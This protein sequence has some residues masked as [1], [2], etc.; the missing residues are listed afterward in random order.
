MMRDLR[1]ARAMAIEAQVPFW[2]WSA[3]GPLLREFRLMSVE[4]AT[5]R[6]KL[7]RHAARLLRGWAGV[8]MLRGADHA[9]IGPDDVLAL[10]G[11]VR[12]P[13]AFAALWAA[14]PGLDEEAG[15]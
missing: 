4:G 3:S 7:R 8:L 12:D 2:Q 14:T 15:E 6:E 1:A 9:T 13:R 11:A 10:A 5:P